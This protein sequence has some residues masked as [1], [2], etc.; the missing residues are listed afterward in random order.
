MRSSVARLGVEMM[1]CP[2]CGIAGLAPLT[3]CGASAP[4]LTFSADAQLLVPLLLEQQQQHLSSRIVASRLVRR[5]VARKAAGKERKRD[6]GRK[7][8]RATE[9]NRETERK[10]RQREKKERERQTERDRETERWQFAFSE[11]PQHVCTISAWTMFAV[12]CMAL[13]AC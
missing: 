11:A 3:P 10:E 2:A 8:E 6:R 4:P 5:H 1:A 7:R 12:I 13:M 9:R